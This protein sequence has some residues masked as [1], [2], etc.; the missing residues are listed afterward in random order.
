MQMSR[1]SSLIYRP[2]YSESIALPA[3]CSTQPRTKSS[4]CLMN[5]LKQV[6]FYIALKGCFWF[7]EFWIFLIDIFYWT[8]RSWIYN[9][10]TVSFFKIQIN[11]LPWY[12]FEIR[13][14]QVIPFQGNFTEKKKRMNLI[15]SYL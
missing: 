5:L 4:I 11:K 10:F 6:L 1:N 12:V 8:S 14:I 13:T 15:K 9:N 2:T 3:G 7:N